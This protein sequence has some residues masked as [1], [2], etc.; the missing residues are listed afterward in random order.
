M[1]EKT[2]TLKLLTKVVITQD[3]ATE[4]GHETLDYIPGATL[5]GWVAGR[6]YCKLSADEAFTVFHS[7]KVRFGNGLPILAPKELTYPIP[8]AFHAG[9]LT[10][11]R[12]VNFSHPERPKL[13][14]QPKQMRTGFVDTAGNFV[15]QLPKHTRAEVALSRR[16]LSRRATLSRNKKNQLFAYE[17]LDAGTAFHFALTADDDVP[18]ALFDKVVQTLKDQK[19]RLGRSRGVE[20]GEARVSICEA[21][22]TTPAPFERQD[23]LV[24]LLMSDTALRDPQTGQPTCVPSPVMFGLSEDAEVCWQRTFL[25]TRRYTPFN[26]KRA[27]P[28]IEQQVLKAGSVIVFTK[29]GVTTPSGLQE[30]LQ[31]G[32]G[33]YRERGLGQVVVNPPCLEAKEPSLKKWEKPENTNTKVEPKRDPFFD[34][35]AH[36]VGLEEIEKECFEKSRKW[37]VEMAAYA[38]MYKGP[39]RSQWG[40]MR[41]IAAQAPNG[42]RLY[43]D[44]FDE[45]RGLLHK[46]VSA[47]AWDVTRGRTTAA[48]ALQDLADDVMENGDQAHLP[49]I[50]ERM[51]ARVLRQVSTHKEG[52]GQ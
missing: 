24:L 38:G 4:G 51:A 49:L 42:K 9:K 20:Y 34:Y 32:I 8:L 14:E 29:V 21:P 28:D 15:K 39:G 26:G 41:Q 3:S 11:H 18:K 48:Q 37:A 17:S 36:H 2:F 27:M 16:H 1:K 5:L 22:P 6:L 12:R 40:M 33:D 44:L 47:H 50:I 35:V 46:G 7:G 13:D 30:K 43:K 10:T 19:V 25:Q 45:T 31:G 23:E 52:E